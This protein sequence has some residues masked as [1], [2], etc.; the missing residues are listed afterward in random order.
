LVENTVLKNAVPYGTEYED[1]S[2]G[3]VVITV[4]PIRDAEYFYYI[5]YQQI[6][7]NGTGKYA[8]LSPMRNMS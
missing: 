3:L 7:P 4:R 2:N 5:F 1:I 6:V 8:W